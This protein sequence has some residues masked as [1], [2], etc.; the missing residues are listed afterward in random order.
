MK[1]KV[2]QHKIHTYSSDTVMS[3]TRKGFRLQSIA[4]FVNGNGSQS[5]V[6]IKN[7]L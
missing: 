1:Y 2:K 7:R 4:H 6:L 5:Y 3:M